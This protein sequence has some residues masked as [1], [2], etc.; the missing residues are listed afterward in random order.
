MKRKE[1]R[2]WLALLAAGMAVSM[3]ACGSSGSG[4][5]TTEAAQTESTQETEAQGISGSYEATAQGYGGDV[6]VTLTLEN[7]VLTGVT[8]VGDSETESIGGRALELMPE[9][10]IASGSIEVDGVSGATYTSNAIL[11]AAAAAL[12]QS[13]T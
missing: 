4:T 13:G 12:E 3:T 8:A 11:E 5:A 9:S 6:V 7:G 10:M 2:F 1:G